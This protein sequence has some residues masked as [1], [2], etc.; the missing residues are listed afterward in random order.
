M[1][2]TEYAG[3]EMIYWRLRAPGMVM[4]CLRRVV[5]LFDTFRIAVLLLTR[6]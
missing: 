5:I 1:C 2:G 3:G 4:R 6:L